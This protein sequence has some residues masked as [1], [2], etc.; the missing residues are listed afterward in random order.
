MPEAISRKFEDECLWVSFR[1][2][3]MLNVHGTS[4]VP[5]AAWTN[6]NTTQIKLFI[7]ELY[8]QYGIWIQRNESI[9]G[10]GAM[11]IF[12]L[13]TVRVGNYSACK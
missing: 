4:E 7:I 3:G 8:R 11:N 12:S 1:S 13:K 6:V 10:G 2:V 9:G 5:H